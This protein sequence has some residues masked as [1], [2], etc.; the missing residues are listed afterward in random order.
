MKRLK[1][2]FFTLRHIKLSQLAYR[3]YYRLC[4]PRLRHLD[5]PRLRGVLSCWAGETFLKPATDDGETF[6][7]LGQTGY[8]KEGW[9]NPAYPKLWLYNLHYQD[10]LNSVE[11]DD[12]VCLCQHLIKRWMSDNPPFTGN[13]WEPYCLSL[14]IVNWVK[15]LARQG[16]NE[17]GSEWLRSLAT[18][19]DALA[20][21][22]EFHILANHLFANAKALIFAGGFF[23]GKQG[24]A[25]LESGLKLLDSEL[26]EQFL[27]DGGHYERSPMYHA[28]LLWDVCDLLQ[29]LE[30]TQLNSL[31]KRSEQLQRILT[32]GMRWL[33]KMVHPDGGIAFFNDATFGIAPTLHDLERYCSRLGLTVSE[34]LGE[35]EG[36]SATRLEASGYTVVDH[37]TQHRALLNMAE[38]GPAYQPGHAHADTLSFELSLFGQR[39][40]VN[41]GTSQYGLGPEREYQRGTCAHNTVEVEDEN[42]SEIW[43]GFRVARRARPSNISVSSNETALC[44]SAAHD[45]Y[46]RLPGKVLTKRTWSFEEGIMQVVDQLSGR[47]SEAI[48]RFYCHP[49]VTA[50]QLNDCEVLLILPQGQKVCFT[51]KGASELRLVD[52]NWHPGFGVSAPNHCIEATLSGPQ[53]V[54]RIDY[55]NI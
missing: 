52:S 15:W 13:G 33:R 44:V 54:S 2:L 17:V 55:Q 23:G 7:F 10:D 48:S 50:N 1:L 19:T 21:Q 9:N 3:L 16:E 5:E 24:D 41:S 6:V 38:I 27:E 22:L 49:S 45:G 14:R 30:Y 42:S 43:A 29:L 12:R 11:A 18:Q 47:W 8:L 35:D 36:W 46:C 53:L 20:Q 51:V 25:W 32:N 31:R 40:F 37:G 26:E 4:K 39:V 34:A 28:I